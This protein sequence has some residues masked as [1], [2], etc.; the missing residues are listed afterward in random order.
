MK[1][2][3]VACGVLDYEL[4]AAAEN[5][6]VALD[7]TVL[8]AGLHAKPRELR[9][10][11]QAIINATRAE[12]GFEAVCLGY[13]LCGRGTAELTAG[14]VPLV[15]P[16][17]HDCLTLLLGSA[18]AYHD[19]FTRHPGTFYI[20]RGWYER[21]VRPATQ[22][23]E[24]VDHLA[25]YSDAERIR[26]HPHFEQFAA[27]FGEAN[28]RHI[29]TFHESWKQN[30]KRCAY[31]DTGVGDEGAEAFARGLAKSL[32]W[33][34][35]RIEGS[36][37]F[38]ER[39][40]AGDWDAELFQVVQPG[41]RS[42]G[43][44]DS[45]VLT[46]VTVGGEKKGTGVVY[47]KHPP[48]RSGKRPPSPFSPRFDQRVVGL[49]ID[50]GGTY[51]DA[52]VYDFTAEAVLAKTKSLTTVED[53]C[54]GIVAALR[55][56][57]AAFLKQVN[58]VSLSTT[59]A[60]NA[61]VEGR[62]GRVGTLLMSPRADLADGLPIAPTAMIPGV[63]N[64]EGVAGEPT[65]CE[66]TLAA[67]AEMI[68][69]HEVGAIAISGYGATANP[70]HELQAAQW[71]RDRTGLP[72]VCGHALTGRLNFRTRAVTA[73]LNAKLL[74]TIRRLLDSVKRALADL[75]IDA[76]LM[77]V[78]GDGT[79]ISERLARSRPIETILSGPAASVAGARFL[80]D[81]QDAVVVDVGGTTTDLAILAGGFADLS[82]EGARVG[83]WRTSIEAARI[84]TV[85]LGGDSQVHFDRERRLQIGPRR[86]LPV[87]MLADRWP[88]AREQLG[89][90]AAAEHLDRTNS[91][92]LDLFYQ[93]GDADKDTAGLADHE[94]RILDALSDGPLCRLALCEA[95]GAALPSLLR[96]R[97]LEETGLVGLSTVTPT[98]ALHFLGMY[99]EFD[100]EAAT[101]AVRRFAEIFGE[102][103]EALAARIREEVSRRVATHVAAMTLARQEGGEAGEFESPTAVALLE[104]ALIGHEVAELME[105]S[106]HC[107][108]P[109]VAI[110][111]PV[112]AYLPRAA[113]LL[114]AELVIP[115]HADVA[116]AVG[117]IAADVV[118]RE[119]ILIRPD[120]G[121]GY[122]IL[123][124]DRRVMMDLEKAVSF[125]EAECRR[126]LAN[127]AGEAGTTVRD[128][129]IRR[130]EQRG[131]TSGGDRVLVEIRIEGAA[132]GKPV[133]PAVG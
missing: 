55:R 56:L 10:E 7:M 122:L 89:R 133:V 130:H 85:G 49:G 43:S 58:L 95:S 124:R 41:Q 121:G 46:A 131:L 80:T 107:R 97:R 23:Q 100:A 88:K 48:G 110:G 61:V 82:E 71:V 37:T 40:L 129:H 20:T 120:V 84:E 132:I 102:E 94:R 16:R 98:D 52:V 109:I 9:R 79:L 14:D 105:V 118:L 31:I 74:P 5:V 4:S 18:V 93:I 57:P 81:L 103:P 114:H 72:V 19:Q 70:E 29:I 11:V 3:V 111:A 66:A 90:I 39:M 24:G 38:F 99:R 62:G 59:L 26:R 8:S 63:M 75:S 104:T 13:G 77:V 32:D 112:V 27:D 65:N 1:Y 101:E 22:E 30:Y 54:Q 47:A 25:D 78:K 53:Y 128:V 15:I 123:G 92:C 69:R 108:R 119:T 6:G 17:A 67:A 35:E 12:D 44:G 87:C 68:E 115:D 76:P 60:T 42:A 33:E 21:K 127:E 28:A 116:N 34:Y 126:R 73:A 50:A 86:V 96:T 125:A 36:L 2:K 91:A 106:L 51:T 64:I 113:E 45:R 83:G 117:A